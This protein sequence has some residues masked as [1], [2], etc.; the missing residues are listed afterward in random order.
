[1]DRQAYCRSYS[2]IIYPE[3]EKVRNISSIIFEESINRTGNGI[4]SKKCSVVL[5]GRLNR[6]PFGTGTNTRWAVMVTKELFIN[7]SLTG[8]KFG[9]YTGHWKT[10][11][12][13]EAVIPVQAWIAC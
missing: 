6:S 8:T 13:K 5:H 11:A 2:E 10:I 7:E 12:Q 4:K 1:M 3:N 9:S